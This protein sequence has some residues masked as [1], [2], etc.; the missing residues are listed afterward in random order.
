MVEFLA[1]EPDPAQRYA[2]IEQAYCDDRWSE[3]LQQGEALLNDLG[4]ADDATTQ[5]LRPRVQLLLAHSYLYGL[6]DLASAAEHY[7]GVLVHGTEATLID[8]A[9]QGLQVCQQKA[10]IGPDAESLPKAAASSSDRNAPAGAATGPWS[11]LAMPWLSSGAGSDSGSVVT[12]TAIP[13]EPAAPWATSPPSLIADVV[14]EPE[15]IELHQSDP[16]LAEDIEVEVHPVGL[17]DPGPSHG[18]TPSE[19]EDPE[20]I[21]GLLR[22]VIR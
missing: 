13:P 5:G 3:V 14:E 19:P 6:D 20:L 11:G 18:Q 9:R 17:S 2:S 21:K 8:S 22:V 4:D 12:T 10:G 1:A 15:L 16:N 7:G